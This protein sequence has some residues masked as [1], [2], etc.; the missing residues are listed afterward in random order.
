MSHALVVE[1]AAH[2]PRPGRIDAGWGPPRAAALKPAATADA[3]PGTSARK[4]T[5]FENIPAPQ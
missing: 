1:G 4:P 5:V 3:A 2:E